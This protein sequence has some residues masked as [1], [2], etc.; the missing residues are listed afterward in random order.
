MKL[1]Q[2]GVREFKGVSKEHYFDLNCKEA[3][4]RHYQFINKW[5]IT[6]Y[7]N[8]ALPALGSRFDGVE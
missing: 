4:Q 7:A 5:G 2:L 1:W 6:Q 8:Q 3:A